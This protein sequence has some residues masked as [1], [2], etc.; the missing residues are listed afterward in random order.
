M[1][2]PMPFWK[3]GTVTPPGD[4]LRI[5]L[6]AANYQDVL[7]AP[8]LTNWI[9]QD[10]TDGQNNSAPMVGTG[11]AG[12]SVGMGAIM[13][14]WDAVLPGAGGTNNPGD[15]LSLTPVGPRDYTVQIPFLVDG[16]SVE[17]AQLWLFQLSH[18][19]AGQLIARARYNSGTGLFNLYCGFDSDDFSVAIADNVTHDL[20]V[21]V[22]EDAGVMKADFVLNGVS[23]GILVASTALTEISD[24][25][26]T[27]PQ[28]LSGS[29]AGL[30][31][32]YG[33]FFLETTT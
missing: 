16:T 20:V 11:N 9:D 18:V 2:I 13:G 28:L 32:I 21:N 7:D 29:G 5:L 6:D 25:R 1:S 22:Y 10:L 33:G 27:F 30:D 26:L 3:S 8:G 24:I 23:E 31:F 17:D 14:A 19:G 12:I 15:Y 4:G